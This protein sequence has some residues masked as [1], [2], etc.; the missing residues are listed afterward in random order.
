MRR[1]LSA[2]RA[3]VP[4]PALERARLAA[5][6]ALERRQRRSSAVRGAAIV[7]HAVAPAP[8]DR[9]FEID[10][11]LAVGFLDDVLGYLTRRYELVPAGRLHGAARAREPGQPLPIALTFDDDLPTHRA[12]AA[13]VLARHG[14]P[15]TAFLCETD[16]PFWWQLLQVAVDERAISPA[17]LSPL[18]TG[19]VV[20]ALERIPRAIGRLA[21]A[22][23][24]LPANQR[25]RVT[26][27]LASAV[28]EPP[29]VL[30]ADGASALAEAGWEIGFHTRGHDLLPRL[31]S[32]D[33]EAALERRTMATGSMPET[34]AYP[35]GKAGPREAQAA[36]AAGYRAAFT[37]YASVL[38]EGTDAFLIGRLQ[39]DTSTIGRFALELA[40]ALSA[41]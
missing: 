37:G 8:G 1:A 14:A 34:L 38:K 23:E 36:Q 21:K 35:H 40:R 4:G 27:V 6:R 29:E 24:D 9:D 18:D 12:Y 26:D 2:A 32:G 19:L 39:P 11:P 5:A 22:I 31:S 30:D 25:R 10:P 15:A 7:F 41:A 33:L 20:D 17:D 3:V 28:S 16:D 13:P